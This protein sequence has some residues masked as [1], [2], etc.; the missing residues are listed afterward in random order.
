MISTGLTAKA[1]LN[2]W[3]GTRTLDDAGP[4][5]FPFIE[6]E[7]DAKVSGGWSAHADGVATSRT[8]VLGHVAPVAVPREAYVSYKS[9]PLRMRLGEQNISWGRADLINPTDNL[10][11]R[12]FTW[13]V[14]DDSDQKVGPFSLSTD[15]SWG[16]HNLQFVWQPLFRHDDLP[17]PP[18]SG[19]QYVDLG[20]TTSLNAAAIRYDVSNSDMSWSLS[21]FQ[22]PSKWPTLSAH[23]ADLAASRLNLNYPFERVFG[24]DLERLMGKWVVRSEAAYNLV[25]GSGSDPLG[26]RQSFFLGVLGLER[27]FGE[28]SA[29][30]ETAYRHTFDYLDTHQVLPPLQQLAIGAAIIDDQFHRNLFGV[31]SGLTYNTADLRTS[32]NVDLLYFVGIGNWAARPRFSYKFTDSILGEIGGDIFVGAEDGPLGRL[33]KD[34]LAF[35]RIEYSYTSSR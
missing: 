23:P 34:R 17:L 3:S 28:W 33:R 21:Y 27:N 22:G 15:W 2:T 31:G 11:A 7:G 13:L 25:D 10:T 29:Y 6:L 32:A 14:P 12:K 4:I 1:S 18:V 19:F 20:R 35:V 9:G 5:Y 16:D 24:A 26:S 30:G 8:V